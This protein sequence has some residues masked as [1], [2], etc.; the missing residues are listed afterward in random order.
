MGILNQ[1]CGAQKLG[2]ISNH[3]E[4]TSR[5]INHT[6]NVIPNV[7]EFGDEKRYIRTS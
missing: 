3:L 5:Y 2:E 6:R 7:C 1:K 4:I